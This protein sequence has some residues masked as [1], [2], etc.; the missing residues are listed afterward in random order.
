MELGLAA[1]IATG[2]VL[3]G[4]AG[5]AAAVAI[6]QSTGSPPTVTTTVSVGAGEQGPPG[7]TGPAGPEGPAGDPGA[8]SCPVGS[9]FKAVRIIQQAQ[10][11][12][13]MWV[14]VKDE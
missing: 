2:S 1:K 3:A 12:V 4:V 10:G 13:E 11:P 6:A 14:C 9:T 7:P 5:F 8:E